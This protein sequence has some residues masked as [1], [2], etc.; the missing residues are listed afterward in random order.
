[1]LPPLFF[2]FLIVFI[3][4]NL[5]LNAF[6]GVRAPHWTAAVNNGCL[7]QLSSPAGLSEHCGISRATRG[8]LGPSHLDSGRASSALSLIVFIC[9]KRQVAV[10]TSGYPSPAVFTSPHQPAFS[11]TGTNYRGEE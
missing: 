9:S 3:L 6:R 8:H 5:H 2:G 10:V 4:L 11:R 1:M 7:G